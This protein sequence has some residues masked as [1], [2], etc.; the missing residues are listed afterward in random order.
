ML[1]YLQSYRILK[2]KVHIKTQ[3]KLF[4]KI[5]YSFISVNLDR[6]IKIKQYI[7]FLGYSLTWL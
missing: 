6:T 7:E 3:L 1:Q 4:A 5:K 2:I